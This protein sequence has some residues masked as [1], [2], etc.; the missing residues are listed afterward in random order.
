[1]NTNLAI[2]V[3]AI[4]LGST[5]MSRAGEANGEP[6]PY[7]AD[8]QLTSGYP[9]VSD[10]GQTHH[11]IPTGNTVQPSTLALLEP[12]FGAEQVIH[13]ANSLPA[14]ATAGTVA[15]TQAQFLKQAADRAIGRVREAGPPRPL[16]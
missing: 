3:L 11:P 5:T 10:N 14:R 13:T 8:P 12:A 2:A 6:F 9:F 16:G 1:M 4:V 7:A 15:Y